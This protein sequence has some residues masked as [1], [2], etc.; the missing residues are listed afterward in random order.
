MNNNQTSK[1]LI[2]LIIPTRERVETLPFAIKTALDQ[3]SCNYEVLVSDNFS[4]DNTKEVVQSFNDSRL[5]YINT[6]K[7]LSM[8]DNFEF[9]LEHARGK[10]VI[11]IGDDDG[12]MPGAIDKLETTIQSKPSSVYCWPKPIYLWP[13]NDKSAVVWSL[14]SVSYTH[15]TLPTKRIV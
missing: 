6:G 3:K 15:L 13:K 12:V 10:Y 4:A 9:A 7:R 2:S 11:F 8:C 5:I 1:I 14:P